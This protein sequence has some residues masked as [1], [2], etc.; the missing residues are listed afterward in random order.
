[1]AGR[2]ATSDSV[3][4]PGVLSSAAISML[5][6]VGALGYSFIMKSDV[7]RITHFVAKWPVVRTLF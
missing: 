7:A 6:V 5:V 3:N 4:P 1:M 2:H